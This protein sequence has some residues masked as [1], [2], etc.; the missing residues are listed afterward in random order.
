MFV[1]LN[2]NE[3]LDDLAMECH[4]V[5]GYTFLPES[6]LETILAVTLTT[7]QRLSGNKN[8]LLDSK[9]S[10]KNKTEGESLGTKTTI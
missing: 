10:G 9:I 8:P 1:D 6:N 5:L 2:R 3:I 4:K 7:I